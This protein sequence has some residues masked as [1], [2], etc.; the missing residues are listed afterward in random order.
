VNQRHLLLLLPVLF[1]LTSG[2]SKNKTAGSSVSGTVTYKGQKV[3]AGSV[4]FITETG[5]AYTRPILPD[6]TY[7]IVDLP[8]AEYTVVVETESANPKGKGQ[9]GGRVG[10]QMNEMGKKMEKGAPEVDGRKPAAGGYSPPPRDYVPPEKTGEYVKI[11]AKYNS[12]KDS[13]L[14]TTLTR[15]ANT[16]NVELKD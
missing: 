16:Y 10:Q 8:D 6:G 1:V 3:T 12:A 2:C 9:A 13:D 15:G 7:T 11:P 5:A 4:A 14:K